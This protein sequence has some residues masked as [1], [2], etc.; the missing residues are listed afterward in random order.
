MEDFDDRPFDAE[1]IREFGRP[2]VC[3]VGA[4]G[5][6]ALDRDEFVIEEIGDDLCKIIGFERNYDTVFADKTS[7]ERRGFGG[8][9]TWNIAHENTDPITPII[10]TAQYLI[11]GGGCMT[12]D[13]DMLVPSMFADLTAWAPISDETGGSLYVAPVSDTFA[14]IGIAA[15]GAELDEARSGARADYTSISRSNNPRHRAVSPDVY[16]FR[17][18]RWCLG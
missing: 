15:D 10:P 17:D 11:E 12:F 9:Q 8:P 16:R 3:I 4:D 7:L 2:V 18:G 1:S 14:F 5:L 6:A 13:S